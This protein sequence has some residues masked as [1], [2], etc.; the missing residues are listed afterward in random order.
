MLALM[1]TKMTY[2]IIPYS[3][4]EY[5][6]KTVLKKYTIMSMSKDNYSWWVATNPM[7]SI[8][9]TYDEDSLYGD[10][11]W[12]Y[13][14]KKK[15]IR[16]VGNSL[17]SAMSDAQ[18]NEIQK[19]GLVLQKKHVNYRRNYYNDTMFG[20]TAGG[21]VV[22]PTKED[23]S[24]NFPTAHNFSWCKDHHGEVL[25]IADVDWGKETEDFKDVSDL[26][27]G[28]LRVGCVQK[29]SNNLSDATLVYVGI[30]VNGDQWEFLDVTTTS[31]WVSDKND[32]PDFRANLAQQ[33]NQD[34]IEGKL[35]S[36][37]IPTVP[38][39]NQVA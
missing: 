34:I 24:Q 9:I 8:E 31:C 6:I 33:C 15:G 25:A 19:N 23:I 4:F 12:K 3:E 29:S 11:V 18:K 5:Q 22:S 37:V 30:Y 20:I 2:E 1:R 13:C 27:E 10:D 32:I 14:D 36:S 17:E 26:I 35:P 39:A 38:V 16:G 7:E 28:Q 21:Q